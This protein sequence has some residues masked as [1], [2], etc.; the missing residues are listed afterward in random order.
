MRPSRPRSGRSTAASIERAGAAADADRARRQRAR[1]RRADGRAR[2]G[3][4]GAARSPRRPPHDAARPSSRPSPQAL[5]ARTRPATPRSGDCVAQPALRGLPQ[6]GDEGLHRRAGSQLPRR[7]TAGRPRLVPRRGRAARGGRTAARRPAAALRRAAS[8]A[9]SRGFA[10]AAE[11]PYLPD[12]ARL[13]RCW[14]EAHAPPTR[15]LL[16]AAWLARLRARAARAAWCCAPH[17]AARWAW[18]GDAADLHDLAAQPRRWQR[19][20][21]DSSGRAKA[22]CSTRPADAVHWRA[23]GAGRLRLSRCLRGGA[24]ARP[25]RPNAALDGRPRCRPRRPA[26]RPAARRRLDRRQPA[27]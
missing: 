11:L 13:D 18:F 14:T 9:S 12:V 22:R 4:G 8:P 3:R 10:P 21:R 6:H 26:R 23:V 24:A 17:P 15:P 20:R 1:L 27:P 25:K 7:G 2:A 16:D 5:F 19:D